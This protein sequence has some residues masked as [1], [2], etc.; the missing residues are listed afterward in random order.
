MHAFLYVTSVIPSFPYQ[1]SY[2]ASHDPWYN[3][4]EDEYQ[5]RILWWWIGWFRHALNSPDDKGPSEESDDPRYSP[6]NSN[7]C[8]FVY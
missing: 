1:V 5:R 3:E 6:A 4:Y 7:E 8:D 2:E